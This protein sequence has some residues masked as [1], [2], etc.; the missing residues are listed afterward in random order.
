MSNLTINTKHYLK[1]YDEFVKECEKGFGTALFQCK[2]LTAG[3]HCGWTE[4]LYEAQCDF[5]AIVYTQTRVWEYHYNGTIG[6]GLTLDEAIDN[7]KVEY[8]EAFYAK[9]QV[10]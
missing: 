4:S 6:R 8:D 7:H 9:G 10:D 3:K 1:S 5:T 2:N